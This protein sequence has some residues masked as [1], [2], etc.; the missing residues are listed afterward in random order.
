LEA[1]V[2]RS[3]DASDHNLPLMLWYAAEPLAVLDASR[4]LQMAEKSKIPNLLPYMIR[5]VGEINTSTAKKS[6]EASKERLGQKSD[7]EGKDNQKLIDSILT[8]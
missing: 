4:A 1:L 6:L 7:V 8:K 3:E 5:R 2:Q